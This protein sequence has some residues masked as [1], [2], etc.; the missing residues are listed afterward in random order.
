[1]I[2]GS[3]SHEWPRTMGRHS[4]SRLVIL[5][6]R[7]RVEMIAH[8]QPLGDAARRDERGQ[9]WLC[10]R[11]ATECGDDC[12]SIYPHLWHLKQQNGFR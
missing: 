9:T 1:M 12:R 2:A 7:E 4:T 5:L 8:D 10:R 6:V 11:V 3:G